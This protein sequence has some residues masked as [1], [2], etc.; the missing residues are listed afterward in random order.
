MG[1][2]KI[3][4]GQVVQSTA[5]RDKEQ[6]YIVVSLEDDRFVYL[7]NGHKRKV[8]NPKKKN[9]SHVK[10]IGIDR[11]IKGILESDKKLD[12][13]ELRRAVKELTD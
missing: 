13:G 9:L 11:K 8:S 10:V 12:N 2:E 1:S 7:A 6:T 5:G 3:V 4:L